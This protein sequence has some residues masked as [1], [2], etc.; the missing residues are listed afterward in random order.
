[1]KHNVT[2]DNSDKGAVRRFISRTKKLADKMGD[3]LSSMSLPE[4]TNA[5]VDIV[6]DIHNRRHTKRNPEIWSPISRLLSLRLSA[7]GSTVKLGT[8]GDCRPLQL[9]ITKLKRDEKGIILN[10]DEIDWLESNDIAAD[11][12]DW[13]DWKNRYH[14]TSITSTEFLRTRSLL[15]NENKKEYRRIHGG[16]TS[17]FLGFRML[18]VHR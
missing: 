4:L 1:M 13:G 2:L 9:I 14:A 11:P 17:I 5:S 18:Y 12:Y 7:L 10:E 6:R 3:G 15:S 16:W 8:K